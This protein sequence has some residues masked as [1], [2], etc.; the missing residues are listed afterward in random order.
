MRIN[1]RE[2]VSDHSTGYWIDSQ[3]QTQPVL[4]SPIPVQTILKNFDL[5]TNILHI[6]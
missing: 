2:L 1:D 5:K 4:A 6:F 3:L